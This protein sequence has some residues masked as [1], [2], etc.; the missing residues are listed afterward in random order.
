MRP[1]STGIECPASRAALSNVLAAALL[2]SGCSLMGL[3]SELGGESCASQPAEF[4]GHLA[5]VAP[6][7]DACLTWQC[8][9]GTCVVDARD[10]D[11]DGAPDPMCVGEGDPGADCDESDA[12]RAPGRPEVCDGIDNDCDAR[13]DEDALTVTTA[14]TLDSSLD[15]EPDVVAFAGGSGG[16]L[17]ALASSSEASMT[18]LPALITTDRSG[19]TPTQAPLATTPEVR[20]REVRGMASVA[21]GPTQL[22]GL[23]PSGCQRLV[24]GLAVM[25]PAV[26][27]EPYNFEAGLPRA[28]GASCESPLD[29]NVAGTALPALSADP[30]GRV[31]AAWLQTDLASADLPPR[32]CGRAVAAEVLLSAGWAGPGSLA[33]GGGAALDVG[34]SLVT[35]AP[36]VLAVAG[37]FL[38]AFAGADG[39][40]VVHRVNVENATIGALSASLVHTEPASPA[41]AASDVTLALG[42]A[43]GADVV[44]GLAWRSGACGAAGDVSFLSLAVGAESVRAEGTARTLVAGADAP[45]LAYQPSLGQWAVAARR[46]ADT[47]LQRADEGGAPLG[48]EVR[49][50]ASSPDGRHQLFAGEGPAF[51]HLGWQRSERPAG[52][53]VA[54]S[55]GCLRTPR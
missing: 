48:A 46:G 53:F 32:E 41:G 37:G 22:V 28:D 7:G 4:C 5:S 47:V 51:V 31:L 30:M 45:R 43:R 49:V 39:G 29:M 50:A 42:P 15:A 33:V 26:H 17:H 52:R 19:I 3:S 11:A 20:S 13:I 6:T 38:A 24:L 12:S 2:L 1:R 54:T 16:A 40:V 10:G 55:L 18:L 8:R 27:I 25:L 44:V 14:W 34:A 36:A 35:A 23:V 21:F 9:T